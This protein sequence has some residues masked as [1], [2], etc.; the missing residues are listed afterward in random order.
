MAEREQTV[1]EQEQIN[2]NGNKPIVN[3]KKSPANGNKIK[4]NRNKSSTRLKSF[5]DRPNFFNLEKKRSS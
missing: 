4:M 1:G 3:G 5:Q 2:L